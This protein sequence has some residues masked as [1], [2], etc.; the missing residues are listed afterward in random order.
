MG[1]E[2][3]AVIRVVLDTNVLVSA[4]LFRGELAKIADL[5]KGG[6]I[7]PVVSRE[8]FDE[9]RRVLHYPKFRLTPSEMRSIIQDEVLPFFEV[10][11]KVGR[12]SGVCPDPDDDKFI[13]C[14]VAAGVDFVVSGD[15]G[16]CDLG[17][18]RTM[19]IIRPSEL[20]K[21]AG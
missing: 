10:V 6:R 17:K 4:I 15:Q 20:V 19:R 7:V 9:F 11:E 21:M 8:T 5:W 18:Y 12:I 16:L 13:A 2:E 3:K 14:A 1:K